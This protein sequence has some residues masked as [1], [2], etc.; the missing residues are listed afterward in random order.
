MDS[1]DGEALALS[2]IEPGISYDILSKYDN[3]L[4]VRASDNV[5]GWNKI[6]DYQ[7]LNL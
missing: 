7:T 4:F 6:S 1:P 3:I 5:T 2:N